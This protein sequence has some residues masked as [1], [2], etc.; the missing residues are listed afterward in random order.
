MLFRDQGRGD[1]SRREGGSEFHSNE[2]RP[3]YDGALH[4]LDTPVQGERVTDRV[5]VVNTRQ[6]CSRSGE[7]IDARSRSD[8]QLAEAE[9][10]TSVRFDCTATD[11][12]RAYASSQVD[13]DIAIPVKC[14]VM[15]QNISLVGPLDEKVLRKRRTVVG[16]VVS[17]VRIAMLPSAPAAHKVS[18]AVALASPPPI[19]KKSTCGISRESTVLA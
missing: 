1:A 12:D 18:A 8:Q 16:R 4:T 6:V 5:Q 13:F 11:V 14:L 3:N 2:A 9:M 15:D 10:S 17:A 7:P 19:N